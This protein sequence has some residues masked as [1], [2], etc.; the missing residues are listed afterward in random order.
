MSHRAVAGVIT[1]L[2]LVFPGCSTPQATK[3]EPSGVL[4]RH[5]I[6]LAGDSLEGRLVGT[7]GIEQAAQYI[8][9][10]FESMGLEPAFDGSYYQDFEIEFGFEIEQSNG[11]VFVKLD[12]LPVA[13]A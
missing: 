3:S 7:P 1:V 8:A 11:V 12:Q 2:A 5:V 13:S 4:D 6:Y 9:R 10:E